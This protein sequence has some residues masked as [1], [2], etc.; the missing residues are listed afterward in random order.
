MR[1][2]AFW[3]YQK[4]YLWWKADMRL[5]CSLIYSIERRANILRKVIESEYPGNMYIYT[6]YP[7]YL[8]R[9]TK[10][11]VALSKKQDWLID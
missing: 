8:Q 2:L 4:A 5:Q 6:S 9:L 3:S 11:R 10:L 1:E 7:K